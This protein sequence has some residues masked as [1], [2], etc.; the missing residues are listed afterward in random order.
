M[1]LPSEIHFTEKLKARSI[2]M[3]KLA[4]KADKQLTIQPVLEKL[5]AE[6]RDQMHLAK[7]AVAS[8]LK[9]VHVMKDKSVFKL[10]EIDAEKLAKSFGLLNAPQLTLV[11]KKQQQQQMEVDDDNSADTDPDAEVAA[12]MQLQLAT[13]DKKVDRITKLR[14]EAK[15][16]KAQ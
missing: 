13:G 2:D 4:T 9:G 14:M 5:N 15:A 7:K 1:L 10:A 11:A 16:R 12:D 3:K 6:N 8:Y